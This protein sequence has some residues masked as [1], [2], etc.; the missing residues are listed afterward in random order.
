MLIAEA[1]RQGK[2]YGL[3]IRDIKGGNTNTSSFGYQAFKGMPR[4]VYRV[5]VR[6]GKET[7]VRGVEVVGTPLSAVNKIMATG[8]TPG[9][10][11]GFCGAESGNV[12]VSTVAPA[13]LLQE[14]ELQRV[15]E[16]QG[17][18][19]A[20]ARARRP[21]RRSGP[22]RTELGRAGASGGS[23]AVHGADGRG[24]PAG[25]GAGGGRAGADGT[26]A[27]ANARGGRCAA[28]AGAAAA[29]VQ[30]GAGA[31]DVGGRGARGA[32]RARGRSSC[33]R[34]LGRPGAE[35]AGGGRAGAGGAVP[36]DDDEPVEPVPPLV[37]AG[38]P[39]CGGPGSEPRRCGE[40]AGRGDLHPRELRDHRVR[41]HRR[42]RDRGRVPGGAR[43]A[44]AGRGGLGAG[45]PG[46][47]GRSALVDALEGSLTWERG[48][49][50]VPRGHLRAAG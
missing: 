35:G 24:C 15:V 38:L 43:D 19:A 48:A 28:P 49:L 39:E 9:V 11:N 26:A 50:G 5:D 12:P 10:F 14:I 3:I 21:S 20:P 41:A 46:T 22:R 33:L 23:R 1:K 42:R 32:V 25:T 36:G 13:T 34:V 37:A 4:L 47:T 30:G 6:D 17:P 40:R 31:R 44:R 8:K 16:G 45:A 7:L 2:P 29:G 18:A 27:D